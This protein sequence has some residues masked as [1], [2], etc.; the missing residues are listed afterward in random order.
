MGPRQKAMVPRGFV[1]LTFPT[2]G[3]SFTTRFPGIS[4]ASC[5]S[6]A[7]N[8]MTYDIIKPYSLMII[9]IL[10]I[11]Y[12]FF[13]YI[14]TCHKSKTMVLLLVVLR[15]LKLLGGDQRPRWDG[16]LA[17]SP[18]KTLPTSYCCR[19]AENHDPWRHAKAQVCPQW[20][21]GFLVEHTWPTKLG[22]IDID[23]RTGVLHQSSCEEKPYFFREWCSKIP[24]V[25]KIGDLECQKSGF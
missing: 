9:Q 12:S 14:T 5:T 7:L 1:W 6:I 8:L 10:D 22:D 17:K 4:V 25:P 19:R 20:S 16:P 18:Q 2:G 24:L 21:H 13:F 3:F 23:N 15:P 11:S